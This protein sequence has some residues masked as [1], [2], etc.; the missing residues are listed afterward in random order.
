M[1][2]WPQMVFEGFFRFQCNEIFM[3]RNI[4]PNGIV[5]GQEM[6]YPNPSRNHFHCP[7]HG[8]YTARLLILAGILVPQ[9]WGLQAL[10]LM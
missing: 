7:G 4:R 10:T 8:K 3:K 9:D 1:A 6:Q 5:M 2:Q